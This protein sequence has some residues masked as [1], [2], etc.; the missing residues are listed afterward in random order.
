MFLLRYPPPIRHEMTWRELHR[1]GAFAQRDLVVSSSF[2]SRLR[3]RG[4]SPGIGDGP[5]A[6]LHET[7]ALRPIAFSHGQYWTGFE[8][9]AEPDAQVVFSDEAP[10]S[11]WD[12]HAYELHDHPQVTALYS[13][14]QQ[15]AAG[16]AADGGRF[17]L[18]LWAVAADEE[19]GARALGQ[20]RDAARAQQ[21]V[22]RSLTRRGGR[23]SWSL[24]ACRTGICPT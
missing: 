23:C 24:S 8:T 18:P 12:D 2:S 15:L 9:P 19:G 22:G 14:W 6:Y 21:P 3:E 4:I 17:T 10:S 5:L 20:V 13:P 7:G 11:D 1:S 16:D